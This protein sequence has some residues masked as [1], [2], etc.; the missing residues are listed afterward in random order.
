MAKA[1]TAT[2]TGDRRPL[3]YGSRSTD[4]LKDAAASIETLQQRLA[5]RSRVERDSPGTRRAAVLVPIIAAPAG[6]ELLCFERSREVIDHKGEICLP[7]GSIEQVDRD[8]VDA[9]LREAHEELG[10]EPSTVRVL[11]LLDDVHTFVSNYIITPVAGF[12][13][14]KPEVVSDPLEVA[15]PIAVPLTT[16]LSQGVERYELRG[17]DGTMRRIYSYQVGEDRI[18]GATA[19]IIHGL[20]HLWFGENDASS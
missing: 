19:R 20:L 9:A 12:I 14:A 13:S 15:R 16:L 18:W 3:R 1:M 11:G 5:V 8:V 17:P 6:L 4:G 10:I 7:G 2:M